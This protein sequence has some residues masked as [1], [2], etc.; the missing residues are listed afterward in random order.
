MKNIITKNK[1]M[2]AKPKK[3]LFKRKFCN[4][5][6]LTK[7]QAERL[8]AV[9]GTIRSSITSFHPVQEYFN[10]TLN[11]L[12]YDTLLYTEYARKKTVDVRA[13]LA[14]HHS[15]AGMDEKFF[16]ATRCASQPANAEA[17]TTRHRKPGT[18]AKMVVKHL[19]KQTHCVY[20]NRAHF[21][22]IV[23][24]CMREYRNDMRFTESALVAIQMLIEYDVIEMLKFAEDVRKHTGRMTL[25]ADDV[26]LAIKFI[27]TKCR[28]QYVPSVGNSDIQFDTFIYRVLKQVHQESL[29]TGKA[30]S[31][32]NHLIN[33]VGN[34]LAVQANTLCKFGDKS[35]L[36]ARELQNRV[37][38]IMPFDLAKFAVSEGT[39][40]VTKFSGSNKKG[41]RSNVRAGLVFPPARAERMIRAT[42]ISR[43]SAGAS[44][45]LSAVMEYISAEILELAGNTARD[46]KKVTISVKHINQVVNS[47]ACLD[48]LCKKI[49][50]HTIGA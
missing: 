44:I 19:Q 32:L 33:V 21:G 11:S 45:Y 10:S 46:N 47:D 24:E 41:V 27:E 13:V 23:R 39:K 22:R 36:S 50:W 25:I 26:K 4:G 18:L 43:I 42:G 28:A 15:S 7:T 8:I 12:I 6:K 30:M 9:A 3:Q 17:S 29:I 49:G 14:A 34:A 20:I 1:K 5:N 48:K 37:R 35:T 38:F 2:Q 16:D 31:Q 40:A